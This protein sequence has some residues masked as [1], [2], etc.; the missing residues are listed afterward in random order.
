MCV[1]VCVCAKEFVCGLMQNYGGKREKDEVNITIFGKH[2]YCGF[3][4]PCEMI[5][6]LD[7]VIMP[8]QK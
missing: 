4:L 8:S 7:G 6:C 5:K 3:K 1:C 2:A